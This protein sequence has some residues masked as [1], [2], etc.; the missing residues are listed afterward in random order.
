MIDIVET[1]RNSGLAIEKLLLEEFGQQ[2]FE[3]KGKGNAEISECWFHLQQLNRSL[4]Q[5]SGKRDS[6]FYIAMIGH[7]SAG[8]SS[9]I[10]SLLSEANRAF[11]ANPTDLD[12]TLITHPDHQDSLLQFRRAGKVN[13]SAQY[14]EDP[15]LSD[16]VIVDTPGEGDPEQFGKIVTDFLPV[17]DAILYVFSAAAPFSEVDRQFLEKIGNHLDFL[18]IQFVMTRGDEYKKQGHVL[19]SPSTLGLIREFKIPPKFLLPKS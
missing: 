7:F 2:V 5:F 13:I 3:L 18:P 19:L 12:I 17:C 1:I 14:V 4:E 16:L 15:F 10:N 6:L 11:G 9:I 8:K